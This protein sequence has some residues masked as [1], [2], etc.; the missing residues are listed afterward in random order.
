MGDNLYAGRRALSHIDRGAQMK[1]VVPAPVPPTVP[2]AGSEE[3]FPVHR[4]YCVGRNYAA[5][6]REMG[7][8][9]REAPF[10]F[11]KPADAVVVNGATLEYPPG[12]TDLH[13]EIELVIAI[14]RAGRDISVQRALDYVYGYAVGID[15]TKRDLQAQAKKDGRP[16]DT[17]KGFDHSAPISEIH[18]ATQIG[19]PA[20][21]AIWLKVNDESRQR[22][23]LSDLIWSVP[24]IIAQ[25]STL[26]ALAPGDLIFTG[27]PAGVAALQ[28]GDR[29]TGGIDGVDTLRVTIAR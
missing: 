6:A 29:V 24:E 13:H 11:A 3:R 7:G 21:G 8:T 2:V 16:W 14:G 10:F 17:A 19:H 12:T 26:F 23:D 1:Y 15:L 9:E 25:L 4:I 27:T 20:R 18:P 22:G 28:R 5:H